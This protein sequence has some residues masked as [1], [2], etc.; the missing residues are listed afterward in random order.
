LVVFSGEYGVACK[1]QWREELA[2]L[3]A[4]PN[5]IIDFSDVTRLDAMCVTE[6]LRMHERR[7]AQ[8]FDR[9]TVVLGQTTVRRLFDLLRMNDVVRVVESLDDAFR[10]LNA[11]AGKGAASTSRR[12][13]YGSRI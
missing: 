1:E 3:C 4:E 7:R 8:G 13:A 2:S 12:P 9:E 6:V 5:V 10:G 11:P